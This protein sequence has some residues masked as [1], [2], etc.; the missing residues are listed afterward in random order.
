MSKLV[1][2]ELHDC[3]TCKLNTMINIERILL[4]TD[5][6]DNSY[7][8]LDYA[9][10]LAE[11]NNA[12]LYLLHVVNS[13]VQYDSF[14]LSS[15]HVDEINKKAISAKRQ[16]LLNLIQTRISEKVHVRAMLR[17]GVPFV[18]IINAARECIADMIVMGTHGSAGL[19]NMLIGS[20]AEKVVRKAPCPVLTVKARA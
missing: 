15:F 14:L 11:V 19:Q 17:H 10:K 4:P 2:Y 3:R 1:F 7:A 12:E 8:A 20:V 6:S 16:A 5:F 9:I 18:E 13:P